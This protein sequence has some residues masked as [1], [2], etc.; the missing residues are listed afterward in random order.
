M[1]IWKYAKIFV[2]IWKQYVEDF[3]LKR[4]LRFEVCTSEIRYVKNLFT[5]IQKQ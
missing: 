1:Q 3:T 2:F 5:N 4:L